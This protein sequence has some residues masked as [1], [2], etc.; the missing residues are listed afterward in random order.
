MRWRRTESRC[1]LEWEWFVLAQRLHLAFLPK[2][3]QNSARIAWHQRQYLSQQRL[4]PSGVMALPRLCAGM[5]ACRDYAQF[6]PTNRRTRLLD[7]LPICALNRWSSLYHSWLL[8]YSLIMWASIF[9][10][11][12]YCDAEVLSF[13][14][15]RLAISL[16]LFCSKT[17]RLST[18]R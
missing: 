7:G 12:R 2:A 16:W 5:M 18:V 6:W 4:Q 15:R 1:R 11:L 13:I 14:P 8:V 17:N 9:L 3:H 10:A